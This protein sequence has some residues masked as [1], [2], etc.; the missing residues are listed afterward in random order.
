MYF[1]NGRF[2]RTIFILYVKLQPNCFTSIPIF[3]HLSFIFQNGAPYVLNSAPTF[4]LK[5][6]KK[7]EKHSFVGCHEFNQRCQQLAMNSVFPRAPKSTGL[8]IFF[9]SLGFLS[10]TEFRSLEDFFSFFSLLCINICTIIILRI[11]F[12]TLIPVQ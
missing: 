6:W 10:V 2:P 12:I 9:L 3:F 11:Y 1:N 5:E 7:N 8:L 4:C